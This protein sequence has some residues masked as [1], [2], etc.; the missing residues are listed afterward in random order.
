MK[1]EKIRRRCGKLLRRC[2]AKLP[3]KLGSVCRKVLTAPWPALLV[4]G[5]LALIADPAG[6]SIVSLAQRL[7]PS[8]PLLFEALLLGTAAAAL[9][10]AL[11]IKSQDLLGFGTLSQEKEPRGHRG[12]VLTPSTSNQHVVIQDDDGEEVC[13]VQYRSSGSPPDKKELKLPPN[14]TEAEEKIRNHDWPTE[15]E[16]RAQWNWAQLV[17]ALEPHTETLEYVCVIGSVSDEADG[18][19]RGGS[20]EHR[21]AVEKLVRYL[22]QDEN[23]TRFEVVADQK[24]DFE[25]VRRLTAEI[26]DAIDIIRDRAWNAG[27]ELSDG[28]LMIDVTGGTATSSIAGA[29]VTLNSHIKFQY[30][31]GDGIVRYYNVVRRHSEDVPG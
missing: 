14:V 25:N 4:F 29:V 20:F 19:S 21:G 11:Y 30:V 15:S 26:R 1:W 16:R 24:A 7:L 13:E 27:D 3:R 12:L 31:T 18:D 2:C 6:E 28:E 10:V 9:T 5:L 8:I 17:R 22:L 23:R